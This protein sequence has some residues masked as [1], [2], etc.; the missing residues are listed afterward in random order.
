MR[1]QT[2][3]VTMSLYEKNCDCMRID[4]CLCVGFCCR[5]GGCPKLNHKPET[6]EHVRSNHTLSNEAPL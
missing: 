2:L 4:P 6:F 5:A 1:S 3:N